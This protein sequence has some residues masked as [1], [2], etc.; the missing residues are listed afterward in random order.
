[1]VNDAS[2]PMTWICGERAAA[3]SAPSPQPMSAIRRAP[4]R[5]S[6]SAMCA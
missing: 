6:M 4:A 2:I 3:V 5:P 1:M